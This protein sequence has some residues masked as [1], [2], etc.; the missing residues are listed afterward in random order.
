MD[1]EFP[2]GSQLASFLIFPEKIGDML[3]FGAKGCASQEA[4]PSGQ[5][6]LVTRCTDRDWRRAVMAITA[7]C[8]TDA[9]SGLCHEIRRRCRV[10]GLSQ[11]SVRAERD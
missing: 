1:N 6:T 7:K 2:C 5:L 3:A 8:V 10:S 4:L 9:H 11:A